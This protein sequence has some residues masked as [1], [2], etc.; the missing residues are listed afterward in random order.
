MIRRTAL[1]VMA[2]CATAM[3]ACGGDTV[4]VVA[5]PTTTSTAVEN[6][7]TQPAGTRPPADTPSVSAGKYDPEAYDTFLWN[8]VNDFWWLFTQDQLLQMGLIVCEEFDSGATLDQVTEQ[9]LNAMADTNTMYLMEG[10]AAVTASAV[11]FLC[12]EHSWVLESI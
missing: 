1:T 8:S 2:V 6:T 7:T 11:T 4:Y 12:P 10:L 5:E 9:L 3:T